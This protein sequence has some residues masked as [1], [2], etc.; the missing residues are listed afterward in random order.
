MY[1]SVIGLVILMLN[2]RSFYSLQPAW[3]TTL[4][5]A[6]I[7]TLIYSLTVYS[8]ALLASYDSS[9]VLRISVLIG[10]F[11]R[12]NARDWLWLR[13]QSGEANTIPLRILDSSNATRGALPTFAV[14]NRSSRVVGWLGILCLDL[15]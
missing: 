12:L 14:G 8:N 9:L 3:V 10:S 1:V 11:C 5:T 6:S 7:E 13:S 2:H 4:M 15:S